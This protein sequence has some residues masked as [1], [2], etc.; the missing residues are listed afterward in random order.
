MNVHA[1]RWGD[2]QRFALTEAG[3]RD[4]SNAAAFAKRLC[5]CPLCARS[6]PRIYRSSLRSVTLQCGECRL[7][8]TMTW[9]MLARGFERAVAAEVGAD[10]AAVGSAVFTRL[11]AVETR[12][13]GSAI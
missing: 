10:A 6:D 11:T 8:W 9:R 7:Q 4:A 13:R 1:T 12:G 5:A 3:R 2:V